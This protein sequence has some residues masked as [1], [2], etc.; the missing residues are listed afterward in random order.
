MPYSFAGEQR[1][2]EFEFVGV[3][4]GAV[5]PGHQAAVDANSFTDI[6]GVNFFRCLHNGNAC[7][8]IFAEGTWEQYDINKHLLR[9]GRTQ[10]S[11][12]GSI[13]FS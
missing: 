2:A 11:T 6:A 12:V 7:D 8:L 5:R 1:V 4:V 10:V 9:A 3:G 13:Q